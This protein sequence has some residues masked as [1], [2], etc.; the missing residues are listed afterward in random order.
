MTDRNFRPCK[1]GY[2]ICLFCYRHIKEDLNGLYPAC[3]TPYDEKNVSWEPP[4]PQEIARMAREKKA[5]EAAE[6][7]PTMPRSHL[8]MILTV[9]LMS[10]RLLRVSPLTSFRL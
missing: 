9:Q 8:V 3:R 7:S 4:D 6:L 2:Q 5:K 10:K 1:C